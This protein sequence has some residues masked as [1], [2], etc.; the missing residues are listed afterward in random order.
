MRC[1]FVSGAEQGRQCLPNLGSA[2]VS[3]PAETV[4]R[5][6][7][8]GTDVNHRSLLGPKEFRASIHPKE[9]VQNVYHNRRGGEGIAKNS[10]E[11]RIGEVNQESDR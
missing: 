5:R 11:T 7:A 1:S 3:D 8:L 4:D 9:S 6:S 10:V 2:R